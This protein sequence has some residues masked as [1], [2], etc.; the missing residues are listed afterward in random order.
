MKKISVCMIVKNEEDKLSKSLKCASKFADEIIVVDTGSI[1]HTKEIAKKWTDKIYDFEW[2]DDFSKARNY[3]FSKATCDYIMWL[4]AD[5]FI[6]E[7]DIEKLKKLKYKHNS[8]DVYML[9]YIADYDKNFEPTFSY[10]RE[11]IVKRDKNF[12]WVDP[13]HEVIIPRGKIQY[14]DIKIYHLKK[15]KI[16]NDRNLKI[17][18]KILSKNIKLSPR[19]QFY[20]ARELLFN[21]K[22]EDA[23]IEFE[24]FLTN[25]DGWIENKIEA[26]LDLSKCYV[27]K[28]EYEKALNVLFSSFIL[29]L[30]RGEILYEIGNVL[31]YQCKYSQAVFWYKLAR[32]VKPNIESGAFVL[33]DCYDFLPALQLCVCYYK[34]GDLKMAKY[35]HD[36]AKKIYPKDQSVLHNEEFFKNLQLKTDKS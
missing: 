10:Y 33:N 11:R 17:Y 9:K 27:F 25:K 6:L 13:V 34:L 28:S 20:F 26:C 29:S 36:L 35:Y 32:T 16:K 30:P 19:Q 24:K 3:S 12:V 31:T 22:I 7:E 1:D 14:L 21:N 15:E 8:S 23:I 5:D 18:Q 4:D 2:C